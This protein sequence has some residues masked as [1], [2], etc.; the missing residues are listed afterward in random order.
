MVPQVHHLNFLA[1][2]VID[3]GNSEMQIPN[4]TASTFYGPVGT[5][6]IEI[7]KKAENKLI[8]TSSRIVIWDML[9]FESI[10]LTIPVV[11]ESL[12]ELGKFVYRL[13]IK[14]N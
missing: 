14:S 4:T 9:E 3:L 2:N 12:R 1:K 13:M 7:C 11:F 10:S 8:L 6:D 5:G